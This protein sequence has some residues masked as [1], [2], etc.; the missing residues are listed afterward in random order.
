MQHLFQ[1]YAAG[2]S[3]D[4][5]YKYHWKTPSRRFILPHQYHSLGSWLR[6][7]ASPTQSVAQRERPRTLATASILSSLFLLV[8][9]RCPLTTSLNVGSHTT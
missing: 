2:P 5:F 9:T 7:V 1:M 4:N 3:F 6:V 8:T